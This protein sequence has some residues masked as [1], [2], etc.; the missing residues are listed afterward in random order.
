MNIAKLMAQAKK[1]QKEISQKSDDFNKEEFAFEFQN[2]LIKTKFLGNLE[3]QELIIDKKIID[4][5]DIETLQDLV[6][7]AI[8]ESIKNIN[9]KKQEILGSSVP[10]GLF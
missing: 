7:N 3:L 6:I 4:A 9:K 10:A 8:N 5:D 2:G 1:M